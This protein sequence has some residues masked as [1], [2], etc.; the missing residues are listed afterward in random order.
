[1]TKEVRQLMIKKAYFSQIGKRQILQ[2]RGVGGT[3]ISWLRFLEKHLLFE[4]LPITPI[5]SLAKPNSLNKIHLRFSKF[6]GQK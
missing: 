6:V 4:L 3:L 1:M 5:F 2:E